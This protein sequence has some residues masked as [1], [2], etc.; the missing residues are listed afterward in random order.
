[1]DGVNAYRVLECMHPNASQFYHIQVDG[2]YTLTATR[3]HPFFVANKGWTIAKHVDVGD[4]LVTTDG[5]LVPVTARRVERFDQPVATFNLQVEDVSTYFVGGGPAV[6]MHNAG[7]S[8]PRFQSRLY[9]GFGAKGPRQRVP[10]PADPSRAVDTDGASSYGS[11][12]P[13]EAGRFMGVRATEGNKGN[14]GAVNDAQLAENGLVAPI[15]FR[16]SAGKG[17]RED[18]YYRLCVVPVRVP[19]LAERLDDIPLL[20]DFFAERC[21]QAYKL[22]RIAVGQPKLDRLKRDVRRASTDQER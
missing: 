2:C 7:P 21:S 5:T 8:D 1:M 16:P 9:W 18:L 11:N 6:W 14:H 12:S 15:S 10:D 3:N 4:Q 19:T 20:I 17:F 13:G 22:P